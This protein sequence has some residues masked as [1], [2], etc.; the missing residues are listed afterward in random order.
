[1]DQVAD[2]LDLGTGQADRTEIPKAEMVLRALGLELVAL[3]DELIGECAAVLDDLRGVS[4]ECGVS[5]LLECDGDT[6]DGLKQGCRV[7][8]VTFSEAGIGVM[9]RTLLWGPPWQAGKTASL[10]RFSRSASL[11]FRKKIIPARG[12][13]RVLWL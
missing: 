9:V 1:M 2:F 4:L 11:S 5:G 7:S 10:M 13:R 12:P 6:G 3:L 8:F